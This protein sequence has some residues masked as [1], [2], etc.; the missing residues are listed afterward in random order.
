MSG[1]TC[2][3]G[4]SDDERTRHGVTTA[5]RWIDARP[6]T[7]GRLPT[8]AARL[9]GR[10]YGG[11]DVE[12]VGDFVAATRAG[13]GGAISV[14]QLCYVD[15]DASHVARTAGETYRFRCFFDG[16][17]LSFLVDEPVEIATETPAGTTVDI[18]TT[19]DDTVESTPEGAVVSFGV[20]RDVE[21]PGDGGPVPADVYAA[22]CPYVRAFRTR[23]AYE[24][25]AAAVDAATFAMP[26][27]AGL[28]IA[29]GLT[30]E[31]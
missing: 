21:V 12:T 10:F 17:A 13:A 3:C 9:L 4:G 2:S 28:P 22:V 26:L 15:G 7:E 30:E 20:A 6:V 27:S 19:P 1:D 5:D 11:D 29:R 23:E 16:V 14:D 25:W 24:G 18:R 8:D 31:S